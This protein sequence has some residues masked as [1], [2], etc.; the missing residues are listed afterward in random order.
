MKKIAIYLMLYLMISQSCFGDIVAMFGGSSSAATNGGYVRT[1]ESTVAAAFAANGAAVDSGSGTFNITDA[2]GLGITLA[3]AG[4]ADDAEVG[5][6]VYVTFTG[7]TYVDGRYRVSGISGIPNS[8][9]I[10]VSYQG[11]DSTNQASQWAVGGAIPVTGAELQTAFDDTVHLTAASQNV[12]VNV[13]NP[14]AITIT[15]QVDADAAGAGGG[16]EKVFQGADSSYVR[17]TKGNHSTFNAGAAPGL[18][19]NAF[20]TFQNDGWKVRNIEVIDAGGTGEV[21][22]ANENG[23]EISVAEGFVMEDCHITGCYQGIFNDFNGRGSSFRDVH[24]EDCDQNVLWVRGSFNFVDSTIEITGTNEID[25]DGPC[26]FI[27]CTIIGGGD[28]ID[29]IANGTLMVMNCSFYNQSVSCISANEA[30]A[31]VF[32]LGNIFYVNTAAA[33]FGIEILDGFLYEDWNITNADATHALFFNAAG[34]DFI[35][36]NSVSNL[37]FTNTDPFT[38][39]SGSNFKPNRGQTI[40]DTYVVDVGPLTTFPSSTTAGG[41]RSLGAYS[42]FDLPAVANVDPGDT[43]YGETGTASG[44]AGGGQPV[45]GG[46]VVR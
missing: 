6:Y 2:G 34:R 31:S 7:D 5:M 46:S 13:Y 44:G 18:N 45:I 19:G 38:N 9:D 35:G 30:D 42:T 28:G 21:A 37:S 39:A 43:V 22:T 8:I 20:F 26:A 32:A 4:A 17:L 16:Y 11:G 15:T 1:D 40:A 3:T 12:Y 27:N 24:V 25:A 14:S 41:N 36:S 29:Y 23:V 10:D 33:D